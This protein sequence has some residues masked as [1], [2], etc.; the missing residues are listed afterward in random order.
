MLTAVHLNTSPVFYSYLFRPYS[1]HVGAGINAVW[2]LLMVV[3]LGSIYF[4]ATLSFAGQII[5]ELA[6]AWVLLAGFAI[7]M[8]KQ[9]V[10]KWPFGGDRFVFTS[11]S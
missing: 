9:I 11:R 7:W 5:D 6:I 4:H 10:A 2:L 1:K 3:G 8:P